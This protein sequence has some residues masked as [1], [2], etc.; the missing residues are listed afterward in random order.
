MRKYFF[1]LP[2]IFIIICAS[3]IIY[4]N[5]FGIK[6]QKFNELIYSK[7]TQL[8][9]KLNA[10]IEDVF[11]K[12]NISEKSLDIQTKDVELQINNEKLLLDKIIAKL[13]IKDL[14]QDKN[15]IKDLKIATKEN[16]IENLK[17]FI[18]EYDFNF[19]RELIF[20]Q[21]KGGYINAQIIINFVKNENNFNYDIS[22]NVIDAKIDVLNKLQL[23]KINFD[24]DIKKDLYN[25]NNLKFTYDEIDFNSKILSIKKNDDNF[26]IY[27]DISNKKQEIDIHKFTEIFNFDLSL[28]K[29][30]KISISSENNFSFKLSNKKKLKDFKFDSSSNFDEINFKENLNLPINIKNGDVNLKYREDNLNINI[31]T[32]YYFNNDKNNKSNLGNAQIL[33]TKKN[34]QNFKINSTFSNK[35]NKIN[36]SEIKNFIKLKDNFLPNQDITFDSKNSLSFELNK[37]NQIKNYKLNSNLKINELEIYYKDER[38]N[39]IIPDYKNKVFLNETL[40]DFNISDNSRKI[41]SKGLYS[42]E[43]KETGNFNI[44]L[45][46]EQNNLNFES[47]IDLNNVLIKIDPIQYKKNKN[48][49]SK[50]FLKGSFNRNYKFDQIKYIENENYIFLDNCELTNKFKIKELK[51]LELNY[52]NDNKKVNQLI[53]KKNNE[54]YSLTSKKFDAQ[55]FITNLIK[56]ESNNNFLNRFEKLNAKLLLNFERLNVDKNSQLNNL[57]GE[58][59][60]RENK[61]NSAEIL[62]K[63]NKTNDF[64]LNINTTLNKE[65]ITNLFIEEPAP[66]IKNY[67]FIK[68]FE[69]GNLSYGSIEK[70]NKTKSNLKI[71]DFKVKE[72][73]LLA[74]LLT[75]ASLKGIADLL[76]GE[77]IRFDE[78]EMDYNS[79]NSTTKINEIYAIGPAISILMEGYIEKDKLTSLRGTLVPA[80]TINKTISKIPLLGDILVGKKVGEGVFGVSFKIKGPPKD[81]KTSVN[82]IKTLTPRFITRTLE[83]LK[84]N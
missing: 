42:I 41:K 40:F 63:L 25:L 35:N 84:K 59:N 80:T 64:T 16:K 18:S 27:G 33:V 1:L 36:I 5:Y 82:P 56:G 19:A 58:I 61:V 76:T 4:L 70:N 9:P 73:P 12:L 68:G 77:G 2:L 29:K 6:T 10:N 55:S 83:K 30:S 57:K 24:F 60:I 62:A 47:D 28:I 15:S 31:N 7:L 81:L 44:I 52:E 20:N 37:K 50:L 22:G 8:N 69:K 11:I 39:K 74:K 75:L 13:S 14:L 66:F 48:I 3:G 43:K 51:T 53:L 67:K 79:N 38:L 46:Q 49:P 17:K 23:Q 65:K 45:N 78:F 72:V 32:K 54:G 21:I 26:D 34:S 71:Y